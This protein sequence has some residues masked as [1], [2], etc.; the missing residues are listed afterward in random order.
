MPQKEFLELLIGNAASVM[1]SISS[2]S[3]VKP[4]NNGAKAIV[5]L[6]EK[7]NNGEPFYIETITGYYTIRAAIEN[8]QQIQPNE[9]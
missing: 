2:I 8:Y 4:V 3:M 6:K 7:S 9:N 1:I 5:F